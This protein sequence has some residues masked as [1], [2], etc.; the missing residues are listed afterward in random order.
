MIC[1][2]FLYVVITETI[3]SV[4][5]AEFERAYFTEF[6]DSSLKFEISYFVNSV[7]YVTYLETQQKINFAIKEAFE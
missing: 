2:R 7:D 5:T 4:E 6:G 3:K 1:R